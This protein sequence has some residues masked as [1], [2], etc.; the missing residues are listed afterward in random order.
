MLAVL[1]APRHIVENDR[2]SALH[3]QV[4]DIQDNGWFSRS[5]A[6]RAE[7]G[8]KWA[9]NARFDQ[10]LWGAAVKRIVPPKPSAKPIRTPM[11]RLNSKPIFWTW[12][13]SPGIP[14]TLETA[15]VVS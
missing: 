8:F 3:A 1:H 6:G 15:T 2:L 7:N 14:A 9:S 13:K 5:H 12:S 11:S 4:V 10:F